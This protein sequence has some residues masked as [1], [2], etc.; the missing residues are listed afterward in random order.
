MQDTRNHAVFS[1]QV[2][3]R[4]ILQ[5]LYWERPKLRLLLI[6]LDKIFLMHSSEFTKSLY[7]GS[8]SKKKMQKILGFSTLTTCRV[9]TSP[10]LPKRAVFIFVSKSYAMFSN[11]NG[12]EILK[13]HIFSPKNISLQIQIY[14]QYSK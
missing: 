7:F 14:L 12:A 8:N 3:C 1:L 9:Q 10:H 5:F 2:K 4:G 6:D 13:N 11:E